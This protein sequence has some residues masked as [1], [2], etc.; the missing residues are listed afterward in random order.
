MMVPV[1]LFGNVTGIWLLKRVPQKVFDILIV[2][3]TTL[4]AAALLL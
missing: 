1:V 3:L 2:A 4:S